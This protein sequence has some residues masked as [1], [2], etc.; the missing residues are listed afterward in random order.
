MAAADVFPQ[1][2]PEPVPLPGLNTRDEAWYKCTCGAER[3]W[4]CCEPTD[5]YRP[6]LRCEVCK[7]PQRHEFVGMS[8][9]VW[10]DFASEI[11][12]QT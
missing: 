11:G 7:K 3:Y 6:M 9:G 10:Q 1:L 12:R 5:N 2:T 4:G 8:E